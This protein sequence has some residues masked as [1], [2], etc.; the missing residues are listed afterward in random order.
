MMD[1]Q[2]LKQQGIE[3]EQQ[4]EQ[5][6]EDMISPNMAQGFYTERDQLEQPCGRYLGDEIDIGDELANSVLANAK[7]YNEI[8]NPDFEP[9]EQM[10]L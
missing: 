6:M 10:I 2:A 5:G 3:G 8:L 1:M 9:T 4:P 7:I